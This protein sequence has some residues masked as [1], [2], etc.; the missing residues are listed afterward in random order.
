MRMR[1]VDDILEEIEHIK[2][3]KIELDYYEVYKLKT[4]EI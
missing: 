1:T 2:G 3:D 4:L